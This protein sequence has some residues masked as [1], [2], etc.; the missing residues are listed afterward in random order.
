MAKVD[1]KRNT[2]LVGAKAGSI[3]Y[4]QEC[5]KNQVLTVN[6]YTKKMDL[7]SQ[8]Q[9]MINII[10]KAQ[11]DPFLVKKMYKLYAGPNLDRN[12]PVSEFIVDTQRIEAILTFN[13]FKSE[14]YDVTISDTVKNTNGFWLFPS[15]FNHSCLPNAKLFTFS[16]YMMIY[17]SR[18]IYITI[19]RFK[20]S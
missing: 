7:P 8:S 3:A 20:I 13:S 11:H 15:Y 14:S 6:M 12:Q 19:I 16:D 9:N 18:F 5:T 1:I 17:T 4:E 2:L 10:H